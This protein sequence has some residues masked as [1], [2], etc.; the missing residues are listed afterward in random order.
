MMVD[1]LAAGL[2]ERKK[3]GRQVELRVQPARRLSSD[4][5]RELDREARRIGELV[6]LVPRLLL[7]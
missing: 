2:W 4:Q 3:R 1:G 6:G 7:D 5:R